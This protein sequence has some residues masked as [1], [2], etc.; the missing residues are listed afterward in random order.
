M[1]PALYAL[2]ALIGAC[3][4]VAFARAGTIS[5][6]WDANPAGDNVTEYRVYRMEDLGPVLLVT[7][8]TPS[9]TVGV[10][11]GQRLAITAFNGQE[12]TFSAVV[13]VPALSAPSGLRV[14]EIQT[15]DNLRDWHTLTYVPLDSGQPSQFIR[16]R[17]TSTP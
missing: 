2:L 11:P 9:A 12:S 10:A 16:A 6:Q 17:I 15:S 8:N 1:K 13:T 5:L 7:S 3:L 14:V 4:L